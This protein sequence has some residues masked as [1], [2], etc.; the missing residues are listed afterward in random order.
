[1]AD[2]DGGSDMDMDVFCNDVSEAKFTSLKTV[3]RE[4]QY[5]QEYYIRHGIIYDIACG[6][7]TLH[8][9]GYCHGQLDIDHI[10]VD[11]SDPVSSRGISE[12]HQYIRLPNPVDRILTKERNRHMIRMHGC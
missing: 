3:I 9:S 2:I 12:N 6:M 7:N 1:M 11:V 5:I 8:K 4:W 10:S